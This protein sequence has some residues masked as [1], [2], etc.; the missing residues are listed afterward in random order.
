MVANGGLNPWELPGPC[1]TTGNFI[2]LAA[3]RG[4][5]KAL[6]TKFIGRRRTACCR[7]ATH[8]VHEV[9][10]LLVLDIDEHDYSPSIYEDGCQGVL[11]QYP[12]IEMNTP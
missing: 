8:E 9:L 12:R 5:G 7:S 1:Y 11:Y 10:S 3:R 6:R 2:C 4:A